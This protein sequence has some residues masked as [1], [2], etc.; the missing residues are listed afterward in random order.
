MT[1]NSATVNARTSGARLV[2]MTFDFKTS[3]L[4]IAS[5]SASDASISDGLSG[6]PYNGL[7]FLGDGGGADAEPEASLIDRF[8]DTRF[9]AFRI[10]RAIFSSSKIVLMASMF[11][12]AMDAAVHARVRPGSS[13]FYALTC[14]RVTSFAA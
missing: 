12:L 4:W 9:A 5:G 8:F 14:L 1:F 6:R 13:R 3:S 10:C 7:I 11:D 2:K